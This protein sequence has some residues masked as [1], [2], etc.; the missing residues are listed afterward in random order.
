MGKQ[1][2]QQAAKRR[3]KKEATKKASRKARLRPPVK[4]AAPE[5]SPEA[6]QKWKA[7]GVNYILSNYAEGIWDPLFEEIYEDEDYVPDQD[8]LARRIFDKFGYTHTDWPAEARAAL[9]WIV[10]PP[11]VVT[12]YHQIALGRIL[13]AGEPSDNVYAPHNSTVWGVFEYLKKELAARTA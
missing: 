6:A 2:K 9:A 1:K 10:S 13:E 4:R 3:Q 7:H 5:M 8:T 11:K 12:L